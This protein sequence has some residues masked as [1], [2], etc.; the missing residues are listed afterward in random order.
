MS[1]L[2]DVIRRP[3]ITEKGLALKEE[4]RTLCFEVATDCS[5]QEVHQAVERIF[6]VRVEAV[7]TM[8]VRGKMRRRGRYFG[9][10]PSWKKAYVTLAEGEKMIEYE[11]DV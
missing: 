8:T 5:K 4:V 10:K 6:N 11:E 1:T 9:Y 2:Y 7:R 3:I